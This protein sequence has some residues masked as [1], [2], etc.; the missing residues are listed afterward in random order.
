MKFIPGAVCVRWT[1]VKRGISSPPSL[2]NIYKELVNDIPGF[3]IPS[4]GDLTSWA[5]QGVLLLN[6][7]LTVRSHEANSHAGKGWEQFT[8]AVIQ[9]L[10]KKRSGQFPFGYLCDEFCSLYAFIIF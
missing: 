2:Q 6:A 1:S 5:K 10:T 7:A 4:H 8:D 3:R 9:E